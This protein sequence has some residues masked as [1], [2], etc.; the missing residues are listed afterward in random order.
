VRRFPQAHTQRGLRL[1]TRHGCFDLPTPDSDTHP[2]L[3]SLEVHASPQT[4]IASAPATPLLP[5]PFPSCS[6]TLYPA[7]LP[8]LSLLPALLPSPAPLLP[9]LRAHELPPRGV[10]EG[11]GL[12]QQLGCLCALRKRKD[13]SKGT[14]A[15]GK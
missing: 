1:V 15:F 12:G 9:S 4:H 14:K 7:S 3:R 13:A 8:S 11:G 2:N 5:S 6:P 10:A